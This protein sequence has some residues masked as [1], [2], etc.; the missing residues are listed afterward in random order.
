MTKKKPGPDPK[1][2]NLV[3]LLILEGRLSPAEIAEHVRTIYPWSTI[4]R[5]EVYWYRHRMKSRGELSAD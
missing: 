5:N 3:E 1:I 2:G 4:T